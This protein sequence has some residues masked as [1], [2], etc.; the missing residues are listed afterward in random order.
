V[1]E[2]TRVPRE[3]DGVPEDVGTGF[4]C[5]LL[6][7]PL[8]AGAYVLDV[9]AGQDTGT[10]W[11]VDAFAVFFVVALSAIV[12]ALLVLLRQGYRWARTMLTGGG[13]ATVVY[14]VTHLFGGDRPEGVALAYAPCV[15]VGSVLVV[16]GVY[17]LHR[18][19]AH[20]YLIR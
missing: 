11:F 13:A 14:L 3:A 15:I 16:G 19:D 4:W 10:P 6:A 1:T 5:W 8:L 7:V 2:P 18:K 17:L 12:V 9:V 20:A